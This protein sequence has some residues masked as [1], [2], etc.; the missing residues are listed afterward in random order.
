MIGFCV[1]VDTKVL[2][3]LN[4]FKFI[5]SEKNSFCYQSEGEGLGIELGFDKKIGNLRGS[6]KRAKF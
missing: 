5:V 4:I 1:V 6:E 3:L 2:I